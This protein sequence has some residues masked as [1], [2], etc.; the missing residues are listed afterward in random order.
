M[1]KKWN[2]HCWWEC[3]LVGHYDKQYGGGDP[4]K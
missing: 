1:W 4:S 3:K 2:L